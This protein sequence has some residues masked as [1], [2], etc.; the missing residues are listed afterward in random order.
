MGP[1]CP[2]RKPENRKTLMA[3]NEYTY[4]RILESLRDGVMTLDAS[5]KVLTFNSAAAEILCLKK[6]EVIGGLFG[7]LFLPREDNDAFNQAVLNAIYEEELVHHAL[8]PYRVGERMLTLAV[9]TSYLMAPAGG[10]ED[11]RSLIVVFSN[12]TDTERYR[13]MAT[14]DALTGSRNRGYLMDT[15]PREIRRAGRY[16]LPFSLV[17]ADIDFFKKIND[18]CGHPAGDAVLKAFVL[19]IRSLCREDVDWIA[20]Y[21]GE[22]FIVV[23]PDT[24][25]AGAEVVAERIRVAASE[26]EVAV[27]GPSVRFTASFGVAGFAA[28]EYREN[29]SAE[30]MVSAADRCLYDAKEHGRNRV[31]RG[32]C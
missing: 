29:T 14:T 12:I 25:P 2:G 27:K 17:M 32:D 24:S 26:L 31:V 19:T 4:G 6:D 20:R 15:L 30:S 7:E 18:T 13:I 10:E 11:T 1:P 8:I 23:L 5:G 28:G 3:L 22:E 16:G 9:T 21:G